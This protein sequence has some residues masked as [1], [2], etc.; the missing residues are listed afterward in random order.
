MANSSP[1]PRYLGWTPSH[2]TAHSPASAAVPSQGKGQIWRPF[3]GGGNWA[4]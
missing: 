2:I 3:W 4:I 1:T